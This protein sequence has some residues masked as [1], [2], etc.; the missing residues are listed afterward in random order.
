M[1][2]EPQKPSDHGAALGAVV[3]KLADAGYAL[4][5]DLPE[6]CATCAFKPGVM[7]NQMAST[8]LDAY[9]CV[10]G[11]DTD[12][13]ACHHGMTEGQPTKLC[14]GY[15]AALAAPWTVVKAAT[16]ELKIKLDDI[17]AN[18]GRRDEVREA[19]DAWVAVADPEG[20]L[21]AYQLAREHLK[22]LKTSVPEPA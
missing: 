8:L 6:R 21:N 5:P 13:F 9:R 14:G 3:S 22:T 15:L 18:P 11:I 2:T 19:Y 20:R 4:R 10:L 17:S 12:A 16:E 1:T 7:P